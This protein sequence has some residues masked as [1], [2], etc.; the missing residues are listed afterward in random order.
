MRK[1]PSWLFLLLSVLT[2]ALF[3]LYHV[4]CGGKGLLF[5]LLAFFVAV[6]GILLITCDSDSGGQS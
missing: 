6:V 4:L 5:P 3:P 2:L 1:I